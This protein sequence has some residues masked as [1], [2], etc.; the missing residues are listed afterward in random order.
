MA[1]P[2]FIV[3]LRKIAGIEIQLP[4]FDMLCPI[5]RVRGYQGMPLHQFLTEW[6]LGIHAK[7]DLLKKHL[8]TII[9]EEELII[10]SI[11][12]HPVKG[13]M[14]SFCYKTPPAVPFAKIDRAIHGPHTVLKQPVFGDIKKGIGRLLLVES[15]EK[16]DPAD[17]ECVP[18]RFIS[19]V[20]E[21]SNPAEKAAVVVL[22]DPADSFPMTKCFIF[23]RI[24][25]LLYIFVKR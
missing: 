8:K 12:I 5:G 11:K 16:T 2:R 25:Y 18:L 13:F 19:F 20:E 24:E 23:L 4:D 3:Y 10:G 9:F 17:G 15:V 7:T 1:G 14:K 21:G 22:Q 6:L